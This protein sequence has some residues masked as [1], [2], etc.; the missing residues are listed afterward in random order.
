MGFEIEISDKKKVRLQKKEVFN[1]KRGWVERQEKKC[2]KCG[3][4]DNLGLDH[5]VPVDI[6]EQFGIDDKFIFMPEN[7]QVLCRR[8]NLFKGNRMDFT[9]PKTKEILEKLLRII[10]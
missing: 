4:R 9:N 2:V 1:L 6:L 10:K 5:I 8:C 3:A 7:Y